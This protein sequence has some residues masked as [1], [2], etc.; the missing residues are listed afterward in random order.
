M[1]LSLEAAS[2]AIEVAKLF[3]DVSK[4]ILEKVR[5]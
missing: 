4:K 3:K 2:L 5:V 1:E